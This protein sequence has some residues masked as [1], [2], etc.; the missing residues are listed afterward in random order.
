MGEEKINGNQLRAAATKKKIYQCA[1][2]LFREYGFKKVSVDAIVDKAGISKGAFYVHFDSKDALIAELISSYVM[3]LDLDYRSFLAQNSEHTLM[4]DVIL[5]LVEEISNCIT[6]KIGYTLMTNVYRIQ[7][8]GTALTDT[9]LN[10]NR[11]IY[12][13][14]QE[15]LELGVRTGEFRADFSIDKAAFQ[16]VTS[17]RGL[18]Y[19]WLIRYPE[20]DLKEKLRDCFSLL[21]KGLQK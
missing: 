2:Q 13:I 17:I 11:D 7:L 14:F 3:K 5:S 12:K 10:Y 18:T 4:C 6:N 9:L 19:E 21:V 8:D 20:M 16:L 15:L 1:D